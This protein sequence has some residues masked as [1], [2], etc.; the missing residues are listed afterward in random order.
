MREAGLRVTTRDG[1]VPNAAIATITDAQ[2]QRPTPNEARPVGG[3]VTAWGELVEP[4]S[5]LHLLLSRVRFPLDLPQ[6]SNATETTYELVDQLG[7]YVISRLSQPGEPLLV[8]VAGP[9]GVGKSTL[10]NSLVGSAVSPSGVLRPTTRKPVLVFHPDDRDAHRGLVGADLISTE[11][12]TIPAGVSFVDAPDIDSVVEDNRAVADQLLDIADLWLFVT[13]AARYADA[14]PW[15]LLLEAEARGASLAVVLNRVPAQARDRV[16]PHFRAMLATHDLGGAELFVIE[17]HERALMSQDRLLPADAV[18]PLT[19]WCER[20][21]EDGP[22]RDAAIRKTLHG[23]LASVSP[24]VTTIA[25]HIDAQRVALRRLRD[26]LDSAYGASTARIHRSIEEGEQLRGE[27]LTRWQ[28]F[29]AAGDLMRALNSRNRS[30]TDRLG[31]WFLG[32]AERRCAR[33]ERAIRTGIAHMAYTAATQAAEETVA[34]WRQQPGGGKLLR[35]LAIP[36]NDPARFSS[37]LLAAVNAVVETWQQRILAEV[38]AQRPG[39]DE[40]GPSSGYNVQATAALVMIAVF[41][42]GQLHAVSSDDAGTGKP[43][44]GQLSQRVLA[45]VFNDAVVRALATSA[46]ADLLRRLDALLVSERSRFA[47]VAEHTASPLAPDT[48]MRLRSAARAAETIRWQLVA[49]E[50]DEASDT[51]DSPKED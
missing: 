27:V 47:R 33:L 51:P 20:L 12:D 42:A 13:S 7:G 25:A 16:V 43:A 39:A 45:A 24:R 15:D 21:A 23:A 36:E 37:S 29:V 30:L 38:H 26:S 4:L 17:E 46:R 11:S 8:A 44:T 40:R 5:A 31:T 14:V 2:Q 9:T 41:A 34:A 3:V 10:V 18:E 28:E 1:G 48:S 6:T 35:Y 22:V 19:A 50:Q 49:A 32:G